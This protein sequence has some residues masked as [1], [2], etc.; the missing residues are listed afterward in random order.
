[1]TAKAMSA[2]MVDGDGKGALMVTPTASP[3]TVSWLMA[4]G[5]SAS[6]V[7]GNGNECVDG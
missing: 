7:Y 2:L 6:M 1:M 4:T 3:D 5:M